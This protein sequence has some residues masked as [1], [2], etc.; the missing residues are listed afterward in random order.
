MTAMGSPHSKAGLH[1]HPTHPRTGTDERETRKQ[2]HVHART[3]R[4]P[5]DR[6]LTTQPHSPTQTQLDSTK[7]KNSPHQ[8]LSGASDAREA[9]EV[10]FNE[11]RFLP[12]RGF[13]VRDGGGSLGG[14]AREDV[15]GGA[16]GYEGLCA[17]E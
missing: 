12:G 4:Q 3:D 7:R 11:A 1:C 13:Q 17:S 5:N 9:R 16:V 14:R 8:L 15:D 6:I 10:A 2:V